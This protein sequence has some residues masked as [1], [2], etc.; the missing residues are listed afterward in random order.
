MHSHILKVHKSTQPQDQGWS[1]MTWQVLYDVDCMPITLFEASVSLD[2]GLIYFQHIIVQEGTEL[3]EK[4]R[5]LQARATI[6]LCLYWLSRYA[7]VIGEAQLQQGDASHY[8]RR[9]PADSKLDPKRSLAEQ[10]NL[11]RVV[12]NQRYP[13]RG[14]KGAAL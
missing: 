6:R 13:L 1:P 3:V 12:D 2:S 8:H 4:W 5:A 11:L 10:F 7:E 9:C 14:D